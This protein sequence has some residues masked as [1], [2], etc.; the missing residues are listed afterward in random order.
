MSYRGAAAFLFGFVLALAAGWAGLPAVLY[1]RTDQ[2]AQFNHRIHTHKGGSQCQDCHALRDDGS[3]VGIPA[4]DQCA[5]CHSDALGSTA[6]ERQ[7][8]DKYLK[9][10]KPIPWLVYSRQPMNARFSHAV[11]VKL[12][13]LACETCH[14]NHGASERLVAFEENRVSGYGRTVMKMSTC[15]RCHA[16]RGVKTG[17]LGCHQ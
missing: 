16:E 6:S 8:I 9:P 12:G 10:G 1:T 5:T 17:C 2:P 3:F 7:V 13:K 14:G 4:S 11:H 15:E